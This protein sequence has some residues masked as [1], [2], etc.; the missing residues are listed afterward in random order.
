MILIGFK[1]FL[2]ILV[3]P[4]KINVIDIGIHAKL[5]FYINLKN[6]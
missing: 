6:A 2:K 5:F 4:F 1:V 3:S